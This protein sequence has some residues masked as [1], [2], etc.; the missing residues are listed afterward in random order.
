MDLI[1][2]EINLLN[3]EK[4]ITSENLSIQNQKL[5]NSL[6]NGSLGK[7]IN[8]TFSKKE[9]KWSKTFKKIKIVLGME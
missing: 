2:R 1:Q 6:L 8:Q 9:S 7:D 4:K 3:A 5:A